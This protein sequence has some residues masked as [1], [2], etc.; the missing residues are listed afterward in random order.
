MKKKILM[1]ECKIYKKNIK[2]IFFF[3]FCKLYN[4]YIYLKDF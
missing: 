1:N 4:K 3:F 2:Q